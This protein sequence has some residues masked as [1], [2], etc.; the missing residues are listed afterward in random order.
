[1]TLT[2]WVAS[3]VNFNFSLIY[4]KQNHVGIKVGTE[5]SKTMVNSITNTSADITMNGEKLEVCPAYSTWVQG[6]YQY[7]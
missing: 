2:S 4:S 1:M 7:R 6:W 5:T 3:A